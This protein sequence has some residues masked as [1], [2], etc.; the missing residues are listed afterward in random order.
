[1][2]RGGKLNETYNNAYKLYNEGLL[3][4]VKQDTEKAEQAFKDAQANLSKNQSKQVEEMLPVIVKTQEET[5]KLIQEQRN[6]EKAKQS[7]LF[8]GAQLSSASADTIN[9]LRDSEVKLRRAIANKEHVTWIMFNTYIDKLY[10][11]YEAQLDA[12]GISKDLMKQKLQEL[13]RSNDWGE[14]NQF[15]NAASSIVSSFSSIGNMFKPSSNNTYN[16]NY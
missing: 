12:A 2:E 10:S 15:I 7:N 6:T 8:A 1:M 3:A 5:V 4:L 9:A 13:E 14:V 16:F 11:A